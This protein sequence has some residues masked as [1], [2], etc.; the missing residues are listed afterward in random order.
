MRRWMG[1][2]KSFN[3]LGDIS[4]DPLTSFLASYSLSQWEREVV[5]AM[6]DLNRLPIRLTVLWFVDTVLEAGKDVLEE[7]WR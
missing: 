3:G 6:M 1:G 2:R 7:G 5:M 4:A